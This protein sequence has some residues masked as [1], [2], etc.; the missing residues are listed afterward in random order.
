LATDGKYNDGKSTGHMWSQ[1]VHAD[2]RKH[3]GGLWNEEAAEAVR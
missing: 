2:I 3:S 1:K